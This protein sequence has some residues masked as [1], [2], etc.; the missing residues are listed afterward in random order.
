LYLRDVSSINHLTVFG[1]PDGPDKH[2]M[3]N[4][5]SSLDGFLTITLILCLSLSHL[6]LTFGAPLVAGPDLKGS[7]SRLKSSFSLSLT[8]AGVKNKS[9][10][11]KT[12]LNLCEESIET[13]SFDSGGIRLY[14]YSKYK[15]YLSKTALSTETTSAA[16][17]FTRGLEDK[18]IF[19]Q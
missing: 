1:V 14:D 15:Y 7:V 3:A 9:F 10:S 16:V 18:I 4:V 19:L 5:S 12:V 8:G 6:W 13:R 17:L 11:S 2:G